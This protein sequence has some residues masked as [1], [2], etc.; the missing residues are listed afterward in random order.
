[1]VKGLAVTPWGGVVLEIEVAA[2]PGKGQADSH[3]SIGRL[4][5]ESAT[6]GVFVHAK[7]GRCAGRVGRCAQDRHPCALPGE[8][9]QDRWS[10][11]A[12]IAMTTALVSALTKVPVR[13]GSR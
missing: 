2:V 3:R 7:S 11:S 8:L 1:M 12:G 5:R 6:A 10:Q 4:A 9:A 13:E